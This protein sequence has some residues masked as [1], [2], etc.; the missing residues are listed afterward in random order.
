MRIIV[1]FI[2]QNHLLAG[3]VYANSSAGSPPE[4]IPFPPTFET[5]PPLIP[6]SIPPLAGER[7][8]KRER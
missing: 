3:G 8:T 6:L 4:G 5:S 1:F 7:G 2:L